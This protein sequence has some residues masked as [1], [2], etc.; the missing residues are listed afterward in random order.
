M[1]PFARKDAC[2]RMVSR[3]QFLCG[4]AMAAV[5]PFILPG[6]LRAAAPSGKLNHACIGVARMGE[7]DLKNF[8]QHDRLQV[9]ALCDVD[10]EHLAAAAKLVPGARLYADWRELLATEGDRIDSVNVS[11]PD[12]NHF[13]IAYAVIQR[14]KHVYCQKPMCHDVREV[15]ALTAAALRKGVVTQLGTQH[16][17]QIGDRMTVELIQGGAIGKIKHVYLSSTRVA[18]NRTKGPRP[19]MGS[20]PPASLQWDLWIGTAPMRPYAPKIYHPAAWRGWQDFGTSWCADMGPHLLDATWRGLGLSAPVSVVARV[21]AAWQNAPDRRADNWPQSE[22]VTWLFPG[23]A[24]TAGR[25]LAVD[26]F[27]G[28]FDV[29]PEARGLLPPEFREPGHGKWKRKG[30]PEEAALLIGTDGVLL[31]EVDSEP[32]LFPQE[33]FKSYA[34]PK[35]TPRNHY[36]QFV[37]ACLGRAQAASHFAQTGPMTEAILLGTVAIRCPGQQLTW[38]AAALKIPNCPDAE[39]FLQRPYRA[40]WQMG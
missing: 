4:A 31:K 29:P 33:Q 20:P 36:H 21:E 23:N 22:Q 6:G 34:W 35:L 13:P 24:L 28:A 10:A 9:V 1:T 40:G 2:L 38:D 30:Y 18:P 8:L 25:E 14:G 16:T 27:D 11:V 19:A 7:T 26:W 5:A 17:A 12:H 15:R 32:L 37:D 3:R 39:R